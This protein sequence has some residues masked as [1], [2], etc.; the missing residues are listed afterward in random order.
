MSTT[1]QPAGAVEIRT[2]GRFKKFAITGISHLGR[3]FH[4]SFID[5]QGSFPE[6]DVRNLTSDG[7]KTELPEI[8]SA[9]YFRRN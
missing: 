8:G 2:K 6:R 3:D 5:G 7:H 4:V 1:L 9:R